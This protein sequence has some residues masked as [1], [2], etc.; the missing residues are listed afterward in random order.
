M[1]IKLLNF[2]LLPLLLAVFAMPV[3][4]LAEAAQCDY[5]LYE[6]IGC[7]DG[8]GCDSNDLCMPLIPS[9]RETTTNNPDSS[10]CTPNSSNKFCPGPDFCVINGV[11]VPAPKGN[12]GGVLGATSVFGLIQLVMTWMLT[13]AGI[14][15]TIFLII[16][17]YQYITAAGN[18]EQSEKGKKTILSAIIGIVVVVLAITIVTIITNTLGQSN[19]LG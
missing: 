8:Y 9:N 2:I 16:G 18:E 15:A 3:V 1:K 5:D 19:P 6:D 7:P 10:A 11:C 4:V 14:I 12:P 13:F 17:G